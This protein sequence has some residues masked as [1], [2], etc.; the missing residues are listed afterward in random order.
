MIW[1]TLKNKFRRK[2]AYLQ[3]SY[4][5]NDEII[6]DLCKQLRSNPDEL[7]KWLVAEKEELIQLHHGTGRNIRNLYRMWD[8]NNPYSKVDAKP[9]A[10]GFIDHPDFPDQRS[11]IVI[12]GVWSQLRR[13]FEPLEGE[14]R[15]HV[16]K[17]AG[18]E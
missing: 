9:N 3:V 13:Q 14:H 6:A 5:S 18:L 17:A 1:R 7:D 10:R 16:R 4:M 11:M 8:V 15:R 2:L 12:E